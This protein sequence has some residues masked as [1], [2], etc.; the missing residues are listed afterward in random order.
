MHALFNAGSDK[1][2]RIGTLKQKREGHGA[3]VYRGQVMNIGGQYYTQGPGWTY[4]V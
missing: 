1:W 2:T 4:N 3:V